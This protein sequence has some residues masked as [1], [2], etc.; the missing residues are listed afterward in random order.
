MPQFCNNTGNKNLNV[1][2]VLEQFRLDSQIKWIRKFQG[3]QKITFSSYGWCNTFN[4]VDDQQMFHD[5]SIAQYF[6]YKRRFS[7]A[8]IGFISDLPNHPQQPP[9]ITTKSDFGF[10][11][12]IFDIDFVT[13]VVHSPFETPDFRHRSF[14]L[15]E[16]EISRLSVEPV[17]SITDE[18]L[19]DLDID[20]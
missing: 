10:H 13:V 14:E 20:E 16:T 2:D 19:L 15:S 17:I 6:R 5:D 8:W 7:Q 11:G 12:F 18:T 3:S 9:L 4:V 1:V